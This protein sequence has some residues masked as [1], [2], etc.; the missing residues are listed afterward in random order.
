MSAASGRS[1]WGRFVTARQDRRFDWGRS[2]RG[3]ARTASIVLCAFIP[4]GVFVLMLP[5]FL[6]GRFRPTD[7]PQ[8]HQA[9]QAILD[10]RDPYH[11]VV[12]SWWGPY[13]YPPLPALATV[14]L[15]LFSIRTAGLLVEATLVG[16]ALGAIFVAGVRDWRCYGVALLW[17]PVIGSI[18]TGNL[19]LWLALAAALAWRRR[20]RLVVPASA[21]GVALAL[22]LFLWPLVVWFAATR[23][24][25]AA[26][27]SLVVGTAVLLLSWAAIGF[28]GLLEYPGLL[29]RLDRTVGGEAYTTYAAGVDLGLPT[30]LAQ[31]MWIVIGLTLV[32]GVVLVGRSGDD[33][34]AFILAVAA[35]LALTPIVWLHYFALLVVVVAVA[36][37]TLGLL[38]FLPLV[39]VAVPGR[40]P[41]SFERSQVLVVAAVTIGLSLLT[42]M[43]AERRERHLLESAYA[44][45]VTPARR[46][47]SS[48]AS[49]L[50]QPQGAPQTIRLRP[51]LPGR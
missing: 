5:D 41:T 19:T 23:R 4:I 2:P 33:R 25:R 42:A 36:Q 35:S 8:F 26:G 10:G 7:Y 22:K 20:D 27:L 11:V 18:E 38:W 30:P 45:V 13:P 31:A 47:R 49:G 46:R 39:L 50:E 34:S 6:R 43:R 29:R 51:S 12:T 3:V 15:T 44:P 21:I 48:A 9:A 24:L 37:P 32:A 17:P 1:G 28:S 14:P 16:A 40:G